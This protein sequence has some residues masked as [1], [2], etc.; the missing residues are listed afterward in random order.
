MAGGL[1]APRCAISSRSR[2]ARGV[3]DG[4]ALVLGLHRDVPQPRTPGCGRRPPPV[5][6]LR[7]ASERGHARHGWLESFHTF[8]FAD[9]HDPEHM[10]FRTLRVVN[11]DR[12]QPGRGFAAHSHRDME[13]VSY[14]VDG[15]LEHADD[16][17]GGSVIRPGDVQLMRAGRGVTHSEFNPSQ[18]EP[19]HFLQ[20]W[21]LPDRPGL[22]PAYDQ[23]HFP[24]E[25]RLGTL[26]LAVSP[27]GREG[28]L[29]I[30]QDAFV[31]ASLLGAGQ[32]VHR[33]LAPGRGAW[34]QLVRGDVR[35]EGERL[36]AGDGAS[37]VGEPGV[38]VEA[39]RPS[40]LLLFDLA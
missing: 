22:E 30:A 33:A 36:E 23:R 5:I 18:T 26:C 27:D 29:R 10:G 2:R 12:V 11:E 34:L 1:T 9:Y 39:A 13:I 21:I 4:L 7:R 37:L 25:Q 17:G 31:F 3:S 24:R 40:E 8:S 14:V 32:R 19:V 20:I 38:T 15:A 28:S 35:V 16:T 6:A